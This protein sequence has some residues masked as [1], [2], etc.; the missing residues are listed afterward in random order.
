LEAAVTK[1]TAVITGANAGLGFETTR[2]LARQGYRIIMACRNLAKA[3][4]A[5]SRLLK[6]ESGIEL[7]VMQLDVSDLDSVQKFTERFAAEIGQLDL[8]IN[9]AGVVAM[10]FTR[11]SAGHEMQLATNYL[12]AF[13]LVGRLLP[14]FNTERQGR[15]VNVASLAHRMGKLAFDDFNWERTPYHEMKGYAHSKIVLMTFTLE[16]NRRLTRAKK[17][18]IAV[19]AHPGFAA[20]EIIKNNNSSLAVKGAFSQWMQSKIEPLIPKPVDAARSTVLAACAADVQGGD[21]YGP[22]GLL[23][24]AGKPAKA[25]IN[26]V[27]KL[28]ENGKR[29]WEISEAMTG[30][31]YLD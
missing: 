23:E 24:I 30:V 31:R 27:A 15:I 6:E 14:H 17:N 4:E 26:P 11:N 8:L 7:V 1:K 9:N 10:P 18:I 5:K 29:V 16:L 21:Y 28:P 2:A 25:K 19:G 22:G 20:T 12:G 13:A 3:E